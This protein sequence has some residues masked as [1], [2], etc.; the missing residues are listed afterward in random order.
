MDK[1]QKPSNPEY[2]TPLSEPFRIYHNE[3]VCDDMN[4]NYLAQDTRKV[5]QWALVNIL[6]NAKVA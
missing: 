4:G 1:V 2:N 6:M 3:I 5:Q